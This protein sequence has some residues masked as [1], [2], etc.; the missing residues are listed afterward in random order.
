MGK[1]FFDWLDER[2]E[3]KRAGQHMET[4]TDERRKTL[5]IEWLELEMVKDAIKD[6]MYREAAQ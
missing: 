3:E 1:E 5:H 2:I 6:A 4:H